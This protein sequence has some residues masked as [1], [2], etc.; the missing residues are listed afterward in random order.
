METMKAIVFEQYGSP[1]C[2]KFEDIPKPVPGTD[3]VLIRVHAASINEWDWGIL[4]RTPFASRITAGLIRPRKR[5]LGADLSGR[6]EA[7]GENGSR[8]DP[9]TDVMVDL[10]RRGSC[11]VPEYVGGA[12]AEYVCVNESA[13]AVKPATLNFEQAASLPQSGALAVQGFNYLSKLR[14]QELH[15]GLSILINGAS[16]GTGTLAVQIAR[17]MGMEITGVCRTEKMD[18]VH[19]LGADHVIDYTQEDFTKSA[20]HYDLILDVMGFHSL[21]DCR[22]VLKPDG[23]YAILGGADSA[24]MQA[25]IF[26]RLFAAIGSEKKMGLLIYQPN[27]GL[28]HLAQLVDS[29]KV[30]PVIDKTYSL[31][32]TAEAFRYYTAGHAIGKVIIT[33]SPP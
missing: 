8:F 9:G 33:V 24:A 29:G 15:S 13:V 5:M 1:D 17:S 27:E 28:D 22:R 30:S 2:L 18:A 10:C 16:G 26:G 14:K 6:I 23:A 3:D 11:K 12:F 32:Q 25:M 20:K 7:V 4:K 19:S 21:G 31:E